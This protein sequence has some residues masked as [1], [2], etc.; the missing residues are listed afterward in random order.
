MTDRRVDGTS[1]PPPLPAKD[2]GTAAGRGAAAPERDGKPAWHRFGPRSYPPDRRLFERELAR[3]IRD[4]VVAGDAPSE[5]LLGESDAMVALGGCLASAMRAFL[6]PTGFAS[7]K[8]SLPRHLNNSFAIRDFV[9]WCVTG[10]EAGRGYRFDRRPDRSLREWEPH[11]EQGVYAAR[12]GEAGAFYLSLGFAEVF[13][14][15]AT[16]GVFWYGLPEELYDPGRH[17]GRLTTVEENVACVERTIALIRQVN[18]DAP[19]VLAV[20]P[21]PLTP[22]SRDVSCMSADFASKAVLRVALDQ[23]LSRAD[24]RVY[25]FPAFE[26]VRWAGVHLP[27]SPFGPDDARPHDLTGEFVVEIAEALV[28]SFYTPEAVRAMRTPRY[29]RKAARLRGPASA[30]A[31]APG[32]TAAVRS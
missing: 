11:E 22:T 20:S 19:V 24:P 17:A 15:R 31:A 18:P 27:R 3:V 28:E 5:P 9:E 30:I 2:R 10:K 14:D 4:Y 32:R 25:Y 16:G 1:P 23:V 12:F 13:E 6:P 29:R 26:I 7:A 8:R 21:V